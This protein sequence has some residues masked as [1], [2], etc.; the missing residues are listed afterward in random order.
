MPCEASIYS[1]EMYAVTMAVSVAAED[2]NRINFVILSDSYS[3]LKI[4]LNLRTSHPTARKTIH[5]AN[6]L[7][8]EDGKVVKFCWIPSHVGVKG[9]EE[10]DRAAVPAVTMAEELIGVYYQDWYP[11]IKKKNSSGT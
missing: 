5:K 10:T 3:A 4:L 8:V 1:A 9:N 11:I 7:Q 2:R 6:R